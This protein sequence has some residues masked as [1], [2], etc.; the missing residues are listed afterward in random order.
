MPL[1]RY[2]VGDLAVAGDDRTCPCGDPTPVLPV[3]L[4]R[5]VETLRFSSGPRSPWAFIAHM[6]A[7]EGVSRFQLVQTGPDEVQL[8]IRW[9]AGIDPGAS[10][11][12]LRET[13]RVAFGEE[14]H[15]T[16]VET[17]EFARLPSGKFATSLCLVPG[18]Q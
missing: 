12:R 10:A 4:G 18:E 6:H 9:T 11:E 16:I 17:N 8:R 1:I 5:V 2:A 15:L 13:A 3:V 7:S 14:V